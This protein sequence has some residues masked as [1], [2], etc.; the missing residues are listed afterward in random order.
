MHFVVWKIFTART[1]VS[2]INVE[3]FYGARICCLLAWRKIGKLHCRGLLDKEGS[4][5]EPSWK[6]GY[7]GGWLTPAGY[8]T[9]LARAS[10]GKNLLRSSYSDCSTNKCNC[11]VFILLREVGASRY[12]SMVCV[13]VSPAFGLA[14]LTANSG[15]L[16]AVD[17]WWICLFRKI[18]S[19]S[20][21]TRQLLHSFQHHW[22]FLHK[23]HLLQIEHLYYFSIV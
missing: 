22:S 4:R 6:R 17:T 9:Q 21:L 8:P 14:N 7:T 16:R 12:L 18:C 10:A 15:T 11:N 19:A 13:E 23:L 5:W 1:H 2:V 3:V 20:L